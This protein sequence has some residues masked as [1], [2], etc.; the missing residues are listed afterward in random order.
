MILKEILSSVLTEEQLIAVAREL[1]LRLN[2]L[3]KEYAIYSSKDFYSEH[4]MKFASFLENEINDINKISV[5]I[6]ISNIEDSILDIILSRMTLEQISS[7]KN[8]LKNYID[9]I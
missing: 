4:V 3:Q 8:R 6:D 5:P 9:E 2:E 7:L 1:E